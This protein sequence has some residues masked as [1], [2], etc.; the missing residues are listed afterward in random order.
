MSM[1]PL[2]KNNNIND[3]SLNDKYHD[4]LYLNS[5]RK[6]AKILI[7]MLDDPVYVHKNIILSKY[8]ME[9]FE[10]LGGK[11]LI[12]SEIS[13][14]DNEFYETNKLLATF[15]LLLKST[16]PNKNLEIEEKN[17]N[18]FSYENSDNL[19]SHKG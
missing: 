5:V 12:H 4:L 17:S 13:F 15:I 18:Y 16:N 9:Q 2:E 11:F 7:E 1:L 6:N 10:K 14:Y 19:S 3:I 8:I